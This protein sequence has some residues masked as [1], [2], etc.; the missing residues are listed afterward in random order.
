MRDILKGYKPEEDPW[1]NYRILE[2]APELL[3]LL[4]ECR[5]RRGK[6]YIPESVI[7][8]LIKIQNKSLKQ[9]EYWLKW[10]FLGTATYQEAHTIPEE[11]Q[12]KVNADLILNKIDNLQAQIN[13]L[14]NLLKVNEII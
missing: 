11:E 13:I 12:P 7:D 3:P 5:I 9:A 2:V 10:R 14:T 1:R 8:N 6:V 4:E